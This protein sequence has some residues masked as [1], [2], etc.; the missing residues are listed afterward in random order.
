M[1]PGVYRIEIPLPGNPLRALNCYVLKG[2]DRD[3]IIDTGMNRNECRTAILSGLGDLGVSLKACDFFITHMHADHSGLVSELAAEN[4][5]VYSSHIDAGLINWPN[6]G[7]WNE[8]ID[9]AVRNGFPYDLA[10]IAIESHP[11]FKY[12]VKRRIEFTEV[13]DGDKISI[14]DRELTC[15]QTPGHTRG[16]MCLYDAA[17]AILFSGDHVL[18]DITPNIS[19]WT[20]TQNFLQDYLVSLERVASLHIDLVLPGHR[21]QVTDCKDRIEQLKRHHQARADEVLS[22][23]KRGP[24]SGYQVATQMTWE[25]RFD[26]WNEFPISQKWFAMGEAISHLVYLE[27]EGLIAANRTVE[28]TTY[29]LDG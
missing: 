14:G 29:R 23:L 5:T 3:L 21:R 26:S 9:F 10:R 4:S 2:A 11:G 8:Q 25:L 20:D 18:G 24:Q 19:M 6:G 16:H 15:V 7:P 28:G 13:N 12:G 27:R 22:I 1:L 17:N